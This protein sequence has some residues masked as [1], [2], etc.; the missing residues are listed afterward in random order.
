[1]NDFPVSIKWFRRC[2]KWLKQIQYAF[3]L[4][5]NENFSKTKF[6]MNKNKMY[7]FF[8]FFHIIELCQTC[9]RSL[10]VVAYEWYSSQTLFWRCSHEKC[11]YFEKLMMKRDSRNNVQ[12]MCSRCDTLCNQWN[13]LNLKYSHIAYV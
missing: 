8:W 6:R 5:K 11:M 4:H 12:I 2:W 13:K 3:M 10:Y 1:M 7:F 9:C